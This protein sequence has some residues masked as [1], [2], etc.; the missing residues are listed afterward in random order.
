MRRIGTIVLSVVML[1]GAFGA[2]IAVAQ[3]ATPAATDQHPL[4][5]AWLFDNAEID[6][7][8]PYTL[9]FFY[10]NGTYL[11]V[12]GEGSP[13]GGVWEVTGPNTADLTF[14]VIEGAAM[15]IV[16]ANIEVS[17]DG[18]SLTA[19]YTFEFIDA[20]GTSTGQIGPGT[21]EATKLAVEAPG[22]PVGSFEDVFAEPEATPVG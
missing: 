15:S 2:T 4:V 7:E 16:R 12:D 5:G 19:T 17:E 14:W 6:P 3:E 13:A 8:I 10:A 1:C 11:T 9:D 20:G 22:D 21:I 18:Q